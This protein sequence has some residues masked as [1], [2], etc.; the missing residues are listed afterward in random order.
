M[1]ESY[2]APADTS[3]GAPVEESYNA[4]ADE[5]YTA[6]ADTSYGA[7]AE[8]SYAAPADSQAPVGSYLP[9]YI[10]TVD[11]TSNWI[12]CDRFNFKNDIL[13]SILTS[14]SFTIQFSS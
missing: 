6:P 8:E 2:S 9:S 4:P 11:K 7:P 3:Y 5:S 1:E 14:I 12:S 10:S 13:E